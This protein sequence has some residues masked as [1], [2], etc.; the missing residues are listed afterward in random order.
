MEAAQ[1]TDSDATLVA[2]CF[3]QIAA[4][5]W[6]RLSIP[7]AAQ[8]SGVALEIARRRIPDRF[9]LLLLFGSH[10]DAHTLREAGTEGECRDRLFDLVMRRI[11]FLQTHR[12]GVIAL[13]QS[14]PFDPLSFAVLA[15]GTMRSM[16]WL[17]AA[18]GIESAGPH[19][20]LRVAAMVAIWSWTVRTWQRDSSP[21]LSATMAALDDALRRA[22]QADG[23]LSGRRS[24][25]PV[26][27]DSSEVPVDDVP[28]TEQN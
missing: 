17:L 19:G 22:E 15:S 26:A 9:A 14:V 13:L 28:F 20:C 6:T 7:R 3:E 24:P 2:A 27:A 4:R 8:D 18:S 12:E 16:A 5:G 21:D 25:P 23:W 1:C 10:A 11:D